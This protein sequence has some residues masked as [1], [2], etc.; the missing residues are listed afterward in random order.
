LAEIQ[1]LYLYHFQLN[2]LPGDSGNVA[3]GVVD[4]T[5]EGPSVDRIEGGDHVTVTVVM[6]LV[7]HIRAIMPMSI[8]V[9]VNR[10]FIP[11]R[12]TERL[13]CLLSRKSFR[14]KLF[15]RKLSELKCW[16]T[17]TIRY[18]VPG[19]AT[20]VPSIQRK[21]ISQLINQHIN[22]SV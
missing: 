13:V 12:I 6:Q 4:K 18:R 20:D 21:V 1:H 5:V 11:S 2:L 19:S 22:W 16:I 17:E 10:E 3:G 14:F 9:N 7:I 15:P 8:N